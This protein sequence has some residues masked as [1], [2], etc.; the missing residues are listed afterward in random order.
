MESIP[1]W[2]NLP[3]GPKKQARLNVCKGLAI[4]SILSDAT[5]K[6]II[7]SQEVQRCFSGHPAMF[8]VAY[9]GDHIKD[10]TFDIQKRIGGMVSTG[11]DNIENLPNMKSSYR[12]AECKDYEVKSSSDIFNRLESMFTDNA[13]RD[14]YAIIKDNYVDAYNM[15][16]NEILS[17]ESLSEQDKNALIKAK[18]KGQ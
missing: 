9:E 8:K 7:A 14:M 2:N 12:C 4:A 16:I 5:T 11:D 13:I 1:A 15:S 3:N 10:S 17:D 6:S 18:E